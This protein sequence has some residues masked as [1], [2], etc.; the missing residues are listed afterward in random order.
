MTSKRRLSAIAAAAVMAPTAA[1]A[2]APF[3]CGGFAML[4]GAQLLCSH[5]DPTA[6]A[7]VCTFS[8]SLMGP[9]GQT[10][11]SG[12]FLLTPGLTNATVYQGSG[13]STALTSP[14]VLCQGRKPS[15]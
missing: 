1:L 12:T 15:P 11:V 7:Q 9:T 8:W 5:V 3:V 4:G 2:A 13:F 10:I 6:P 14:I